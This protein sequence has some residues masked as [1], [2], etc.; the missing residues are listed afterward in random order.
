VSETLSL[1]IA[2]TDNALTDDGTGFPWLHLTELSKGNGLYFTMD[3]HTV[4][5]FIHQ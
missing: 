4:E 2:G 1:D 3:V 5:D